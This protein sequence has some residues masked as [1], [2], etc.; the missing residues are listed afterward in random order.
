MQKHRHGHID[1]IKSQITI[2]TECINNLD[3]D[4]LVCMVSLLANCRGRCVGVMQFHSPDAG[5]DSS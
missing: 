2:Y 3:D 4:G 1:S 5:D